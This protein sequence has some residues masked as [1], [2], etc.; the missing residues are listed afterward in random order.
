MC[1]RTPIPEIPEPQL[2]AALNHYALHPREI[3]ARLALEAAW[4]PERL[5]TEMPFTRPSYLRA[6][7]TDG[8]A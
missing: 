1:C 6:D 7:P 5:Y 3:D 8:D 2:R 4:T